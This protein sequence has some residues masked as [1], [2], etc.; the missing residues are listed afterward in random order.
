MAASSH[1]DLE[2]ALPRLGIGGVSR[3]T[4][5]A[6]T[7]AFSAAVALSAVL[8]VGLTVGPRLLP[9]RTYAIESGSMRPTLPVGST[10]VLRPVEAARLHVGDIITFSRPGGANGDLV[11]HRIVRIER[12]DGHAMFVTKGDANGVADA[13]RV[14]ATGTGWRYAFSIPL[15]GYA[16]ILLKAPIVRFGFLACLVLACAAGAIRRIWRVEAGAR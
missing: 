9:Y 7:V 6:A 2:P 11:T 3:L 1:A 8:V 10:A 16:V 12:H 4:R 13:W 14:P 5:R 15:A